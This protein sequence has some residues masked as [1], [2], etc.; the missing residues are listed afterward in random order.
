M[1]QFRAKVGEKEY[2]IEVEAE[3]RIAEA[4]MQ[5]EELSGAEL[6]VPQQKWIYQVID[7]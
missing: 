5:L 6:P 7:G 1:V 3:T 4:K 2:T